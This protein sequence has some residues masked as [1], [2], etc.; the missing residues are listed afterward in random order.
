[1]PLPAS[2]C[3]RLLGL[4]VLRLYRLKALIRLLPLKEQHWQDLLQLSPSSRL[5]L[6]N[7][8]VVEH[9]I[10]SQ[11]QLVEKLLNHA[12]HALGDVSSVCAEESGSDMASHSSEGR[13]LALL[14][15]E[16][17]DTIDRALCDTAAAVVLARIVDCFHLVTEGVLVVVLRYVQ[18]NVTASC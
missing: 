14:C 10:D 1:M 17:F 6:V 12:L 3:R 4:F 16:C 2:R 7:N 8:L 13:V 11:I 18:Q 9:S 5:L 15:K